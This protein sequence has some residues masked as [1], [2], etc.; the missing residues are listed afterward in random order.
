MPLVAAVIVR[1]Y[2]FPDA[3]A[4]GV[5]LIGVC[6]AGASSNVMTYLAKGNIALSLS[7]TMLATFVSPII[8]PLLMRALAGQLIAVDTVGMMIS[9]LNMILVPVAAGLTCNRI[10]YDRPG[11]LRRGLNL[12]G[13]G[14][15]AASAGVF[16]LFVPFA[17][18]VRSLQ[19][20]L[21]LVGWSIAA[22]SLATVVIERIKGPANWME[23]VLPKLSLTSI[24]LYI[25]IVSAH[26]RD[27]LLSVGP[28]LFVAAVA[29]NLTGFVLGY[30]S[31]KALRLSDR[32]VRAFTIEMGLKNAGL[33]VGLAYDVLR[34]DAAALASLVQSSWMNIS[35]STLANFWRQ[36]APREAVTAPSPM[37]KGA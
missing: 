18:S 37:Y 24:L 33:G 21:I 31:A 30:G 17:A 25:V 16:L 6:P 19:S 32:D 8:T 1:V 28:A 34:S 27:T 2:H 12:A 23:I 3:V 4:A 5:V 11:W 14:L 9:I 13:V 15:A 22:V 10:L 20:G 7:I 26:N 36:R 29:H 35:G